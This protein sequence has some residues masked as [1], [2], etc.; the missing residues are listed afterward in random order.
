MTRA[1]AQYWP[2]V[3][4]ALACLLVF[5]EGQWTK[6]TWS[7]GYGAN[8]LNM[9]AEYGWDKPGARGG[10]YTAVTKRADGSEVLRLFGG[11]GASWWEGNGPLNDMWE[12]KVGVNRLDWHA[13]QGTNLLN[14]LSRYGPV[15][16]YSSA[17]WPGGRCEGASWSDPEGTMW[18]FGGT[19][20]ARANEKGILSDIWRWNE[21]L[22]QWAFM[23]SSQFVD[24][25]VN[26]QASTN[27]TP[28]ARS[29]PSHSA[30]EFGNLY[31]HG[32]Y[33]TITGNSYVFHNDIWFY[34]TTSLLWT[35]IHPGCEVA[36]WGTQASANPS[37]CPPKV[38]AGS[39]QYHDN[40]LYHY[41]G[42]I[43]DSNFMD[44]SLSNAFWV[45][46]LSLRT[47]TWV[48]GDRHPMPGTYPTNPTKRTEQDWE[49]IDKSKVQISEMVKESINNY[50]ID[51][52]NNNNKR[53]L[54]TKDEMADP[55]EPLAEPLV[56]PIAYV[57]V[58]EP[59]A[60]PVSAPIGEEPVSSP[61][62]SPFQEE[63]QQATPTEDSG[64]N[65]HARADIIALSPT[66]VN[67]SPSNDNYVLFDAVNA[68]HTRVTVRITGIVNNP[69]GLHGM[70]IH[71]YGDLSDP[72]GA[73]LG[74]H[75]DPLGVGHGCEDPRSVGDLGNW[76]AVS[77]VINAARDFDLIQLTGTNSIIGRG[78][79]LHN[80]TDDCANVP[81]AGA[82]IAAGVI[83]VANVAGNEAEAGVVTG[84]FTAAC[85]LIPTTTGT[86]LQ[87]G[88]F[89]WTQPSSSDPVTVIGNLQRQAVYG[90]HVHTYGDLS[91]RAA[92]SATAS[93]FD[94]LATGHHDFPNSSTPHHAG[95]MGNTDLSTVVNGK[96]WYLKT[97]DTGMT[98]AQTANHES[99][100]GRGLIVHE[101]EDQGPSAQPTGASGARHAQCVIG[102]ASLSLTK[103][104]STVPYPTGPAYPGSRHSATFLYVPQT[105][106]MYLAAGFGRDG[107]NVTGNLNDLFSFNPATQE[108][109][110]VS[111]SSSVNAAVNYATPGMPGGRGLPG[112]WVD[113]YAN[114]WFAFGYYS[115]LSKADD[116]RNDIWSYS[117]ADA[118]PPS[119][120]IF[121]TPSTPPTQPLPSP[122]PSPATTAPVFA[123]PPLPDFQPV[124]SSL[125]GPSPGPGWLCIAESKWAY[126]GNFEVPSDFVV[127][128]GIAGL[129][130]GNLNLPSDRS[131]LFEV[132]S[133]LVL[134][135][136]ASLYGTI[137]VQLEMETLRQLQKLDEDASARKILLIKHHENP[138]SKRIDMETDSS[139]PHLVTL[140]ASER[141]A[142]GF[143]YA[144]NNLDWRPLE[145][146]TKIYEGKSQHQEENGEEDG[147][148]H[149]LPFL[150]SESESGAS[151]ST[152][153]HVTA[154]KTVKSHRRAVNEGVR[155]GKGQ[156]V[157]SKCGSF[158]YDLE[159]EYVGND[160]YHF[161]ADIE[162]INTSCASL[163]W[164][165]LL[166]VIAVFFIV[167]VGTLCI[168]QYGFKRSIFN[169]FARM[170][171]GHSQR[172]QGAGSP[173]PAAAATRSHP[174]RPRSDPVID[175]HEI[176]INDD[177]SEEP[178][179]PPPRGG[180]QIE[181]SE[182]DGSEEASEEEE[183]AE[184][185]YSEEESGEEEGSDE[186]SDLQ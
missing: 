66:E 47:W 10:S 12:W 83:G 1:K 150:G 182:M 37:N 183:S 99:I 120:P 30:D 76:L 128:A 149:I 91:D 159:D 107:D 18:I 61:V 122:P 158:T 170:D 16:N 44:P 119:A 31:I 28:G 161:Y 177:E 104:A 43:K 118:P 36:F 46:D 39:L 151:Q 110:W 136:S 133:S 86:G 51:N 8:V 54:V 132:G 127:P 140:T 114:L 109:K 24:Q 138:P 48:S 13:V 135:G 172:E 176:S 79:V 117:L 89:L 142:R 29:A 169:G 156:V 49:L 5:A 90:V 173:A 116:F 184:E 35:N 32:G 59:F 97:I 88:A 178:E 112:R 155:N 101:D 160:L 84:P 108:W 7:L 58:S 38:L 52:I 22:A 145:I 69:N 60:E 102:I 174:V 17:S 113:E 64:P 27:S 67:L 141:R 93:H 65:Q 23:N 75:W 63:P 185:E 186:D 11:C 53:D 125:C 157:G 78:I 115:S 137:T 20:Y 70:H 94:P 111:G 6:D 134:S 152:A 73:A 4:A 62:A 167:I 165:A 129:I 81:S 98:L 68:T 21:T 33:G 50:N 123:Q 95:D 126:S 154:Q 130:Y 164:V 148:M 106:L 153:A 45:F 144:V 9:K 163:W 82:R 15:G 80:L 131:I 168:L 147:E 25:P 57:P 40:K 181:E 96:L 121:T 34:N 2:A 139:M 14:S 124:V 72:T 162:H 180:Y 171:D 74:A 41:G 85:T 42:Y 100:I 143:T 92:A 77:G 175:M 146:L 71:Q 56:E 26:Y 103:V 105:G 87:S 55:A 3:L 166:I 179:F 19:G